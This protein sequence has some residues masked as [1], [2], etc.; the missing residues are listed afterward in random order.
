MKQGF[1]P[2]FVLLQPLWYT[3]PVVFGAVNLSNLSLLLE[4]ESSSEAKNTV[5]CF[6][7]LL[8]IF[9]AVLG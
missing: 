5:S 1:K 3:H 7:L 6:F 8:N 4:E 2:R 9:P